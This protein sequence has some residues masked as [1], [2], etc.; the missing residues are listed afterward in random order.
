MLPRINESLDDD[1]VSYG[2]GVVWDIYPPRIGVRAD[3][4]GVEG[5][6][7]SVGVDNSSKEMK[8]F[9]VNGFYMRVHGCRL[10]C[11]DNAGYFPC[12]I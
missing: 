6:V 1:V 2:N 8:L 10:H 7:S 9:R 5:L 4:K 11:L 3:Y 12:G